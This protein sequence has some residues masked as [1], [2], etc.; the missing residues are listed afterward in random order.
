MALE[1]QWTFTEQP[2]SPIPF[3]HLEKLRHRKKLLDFIIIT[4]GGRRVRANRFLL[5]MRFPRIADT[6]AAGDRAYMEWRRFNANVVA[7]W[8]QPWHS[9]TPD[10]SNS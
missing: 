8:K 9:P 10:A 2:T 6:M 5:A 1:E 3:D 4:K 7:L